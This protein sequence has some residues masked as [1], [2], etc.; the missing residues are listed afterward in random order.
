MSDSAD[1]ERRYR[2]LLAC[3]PRAFRRE[4]E[5]EILAVLMAGA[6]EGQQRLRLGEAANLIKHVLWMCLGLS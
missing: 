2:R 5:Q 4:H 1:L 6:D 3:Y